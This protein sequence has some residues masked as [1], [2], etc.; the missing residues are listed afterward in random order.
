MVLRLSSSAKIYLCTCIASIPAMLF[1]FDTGTI[2]SITSMPQFQSAFGDISELVRGVVVSSILIPSALT[3]MIA[4]NVADKISR[5]WTISLGCAIFA[6]GSAIECGSTNLGMLIAGRCIAGSGEGLFLS[7]TAVYVSEISPSHIRGKTMVLTQVFISGGI[8][9]GFFICYGSVRF[10]T[11][12]SWRLPWALST[13]TALAMAIAAPFLPYSPRWLL[14]H[15]RRVEAEAVL[16]SLCPDLN[17]EERREM[18]EVPPSRKDKGVGKWDM[19]QKGVRGRTLLGVF[20]NA[21][22]MTS[23]I[24]F[25]L[26]FAPLLFTQAGLSASTSSFVASGVTGLVLLITSIIS[27]TY[28]DNVGRRTLWL[29]GGVLVG[30]C[31]FILGSL[32]ASGAAKSEAGKWVVIATIEIFTISFCATWAAILRLYTAEVQPNKTRGPATAFGVGV[33]QTVNFVV[34]LTGPGFL[35][36]S[37]SGPYFTYG[38]CTLGATLVAYFYMPET[39]GKSLETIDTTFEG[40]PFAVRWPEVLLSGRKQANEQTLTRRRASRESQKLPGETREELRAGMIELEERLESA[41]V[42]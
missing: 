42:E 18:L 35:A 22:A 5:K 7:C 10:P 39:I 6:L 30:T 4:G 12:L 8:A 33:N 11:S 14:S 19:F 15:G 28:V 16:D 41:I 37:A 25:V 32:Y 29:V 23:G 13:F 21:A 31:H 27:A 26:F 20:L 17:L 3:G 38:S 1:G 2:G 24:D 40:S 34:A 9:T 36:R